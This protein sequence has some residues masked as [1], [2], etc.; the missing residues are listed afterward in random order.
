MSAFQDEDDAATQDEAEL[1]KILVTEIVKAEALLEE[2]DSQFNRR[3]YVRAFFASVEAFVAS[4][5][6]IALLSPEKFPEEERTLLRETRVAVSNGKVVKHKHKVSLRDILPLAFNSF[7]KA[8]GSQTTMNLDNDWSNFHKCIAVRD[9]ITHPK[10]AT[11]F[12]ISDQ[13]IH[14]MNRATHW[15]AKSVAAGITEGIPRQAFIFAAIA[16]VVFLVAKSKPSTKNGEA[17]SLKANSSKT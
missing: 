8:R 3:V 6:R 4:I 10:V 14:E 1:W 11:D 9:R 15:I 13:E 16:A 2:E 17:Q 12:T 5:R 7:M